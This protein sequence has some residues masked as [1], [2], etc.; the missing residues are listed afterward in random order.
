MHWNDGWSSSSWILM[1]IAM[2][3]FWALVIRAL[4]AVIRW[5]DR[6]DPNRSPEQILAERF[7]AGEIDRDD[8]NQ[9]LETLQSTGTAHPARELQEERASH[10]HSS[11]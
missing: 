4:V 2:V 9:R 6:A 7:A 1:T 11:R 10:G 8:Y 3:V 5:P